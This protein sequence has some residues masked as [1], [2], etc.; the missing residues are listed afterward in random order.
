MRKDKAS[1]LLHPALIV[2]LALLLLN[3][4]YWKYTY[5]NWL[6]GKLSDFA[7]IVVLVVFLRVLFPQLSRIKIALATALFF[8]W[9]KSPL[10]QSTISFFHDALHLP[11]NR[12]ID[13]SDLWALAVIIPAVH[14]LPPK[15]INARH[16]AFQ[17]LQ[18]CVGTVTIFSLC[19][20]SIPY[21][22]LFQAH[23]NSRDIYFDE[24]ISFR[25]SAASLLQ[26]LTVKGIDYRRDSV[27]YYPVINQ[28]N[29]YY[30]QSQKN[31][32]VVQWQQLSQTKDSTVYVKWEGRP[33]YLIPS[34]KIE[35][36][37]TFYAFRNIRFTLEENDKKTKTKITIQM[38]EGGG[39]PPWGVMNNKEKKKY[40]EIFEEMFLN[41]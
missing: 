36:E 24:S 7:G 8:A 16:P 40:K 4:F 30:R 22:S 17:L 3:D 28:Q 32:S 29:L 12:V 14:L 35:M 34:Y 15:K 11:I 25:T 6:T 2:S 26:R 1:L 13:Y 37:N 31:D 20:T 19:A 9:W 39:V 27:M 10:S 21:R 23:P 5:H 18:W 33:Y 41:D 38:F